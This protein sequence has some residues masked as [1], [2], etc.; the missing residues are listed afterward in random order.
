M[1]LLKVSVDAETINVVC[2]FR[3]S[4][5]YACNIRNLQFTD[6]P[7]LNFA[8]SGNHLPGHINDDVAYII[9]ETSQTPII[10]NQLFSTFQ[11]AQ[12]LKI[13]SSGLNRIQPNAFVGGNSLR[14]I[15]I[16]GNPLNSLGPHAFIGSLQVTNLY[17]QNNQLNDLD[18]DALYGLHSLL[19]I[20][21]SGNQIRTLPSNVFLWRRQIRQINLDNNSIEILPGDIFR[22]NPVVNTIALSDNN[23]NAL[24]RNLITGLNELTAFGALNNRCIDRSWVV[25][26]D[27]RTRIIPEALEECFRNYEQLL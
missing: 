26:A 19:T 24:G 4:P 17:L 6:S 9:I 27:E 11:N 13:T 14:E 20:D 5:R 3:Y 8:F 16:S 21:L 7:S 1:F 15:H 2:D 12:V 10:I 18:V 23:I 22:D 25:G